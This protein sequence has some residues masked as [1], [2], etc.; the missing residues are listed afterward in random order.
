MPDKG[1]L[2]VRF[3]KLKIDSRTQEPVDYVVVWEQRAQQR[4]RSVWHL[5]YA[6]CEFRQ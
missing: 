4:E 5:D 3:L 2:F 1:L 6:S